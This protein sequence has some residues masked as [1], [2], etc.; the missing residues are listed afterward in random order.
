MNCSKKIIIG[1]VIFI[2]SVVL[3]ILTCITIGFPWEHYVVRKTAKKYVIEKYHLTPT[4]LESGIL[5]TYP[6]GVTVYPKEYPF[7]FVVTISRNDLSKV[8]FDNYFERLAQHNIKEYIEDDVKE[9]AGADSSIV[10]A[11]SRSISSDDS[12]YPYLTIDEINSDLLLDTM[13]NEYDIA[14]FIRNANLICN[15]DRDYEIFK[16]ILSRLQPANVCIYYRKGDE[17]IIELHIR[18][19]DYDKIQ[20]PE[21][22]HSYYKL[23]LLSSGRLAEE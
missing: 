16:L 2:I 18:S 5:L 21:D 6:V 9:L 10:A 17:T 3:F 1:I 11:F 19:F 15:N 14:V 23:S 4:K 22:L 7:G 8:R 12:K 13:K 20:S